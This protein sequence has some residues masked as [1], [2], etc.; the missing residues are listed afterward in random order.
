MVFILPSRKHPWTERVFE[1]PWYLSHVCRESTYCWTLISPICI[2]ICLRHVWDPS[3][4]TLLSST[5]EHIFEIPPEQFP[6]EEARPEAQGKRLHSRSHKNGNPL[7][8]ATG[9]PLDNSIKDPLDKWQCHWK[10]VGKCH[11]KSTVIIEVLVSGVQYFAP[12]H[13]HTLLCVRPP[14]AVAELLLVLLLALV[15]VVVLLLL[16]LLLLLLVLVLLLLLVLLLPVLLLLWWLR[17]GVGRRHRRPDR[18]A[19]RRRARASVDRC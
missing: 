18:G 12:S 4:S 16:L 6:C 9:N 3:D 10:S 17:P 19:T 13:T 2:T 7:E 14:D 15:V 1:Y 11:W 8:N 5:L